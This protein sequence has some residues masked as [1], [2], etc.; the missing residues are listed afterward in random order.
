MTTV[1]QDAPGE[2]LAERIGFTRRW[3]MDRARGWIET[4]RVCRING[5]ARAAALHLSFAGECRRDAL[6]VGRA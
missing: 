4:A 2:S 1:V 3:Y 6:S 5:R